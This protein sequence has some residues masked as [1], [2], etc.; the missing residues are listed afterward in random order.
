MSFENTYMFVILVRLE[1]TFLD[2]RGEQNLEKGEI[3]REQ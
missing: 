1:P 2:L 3:L